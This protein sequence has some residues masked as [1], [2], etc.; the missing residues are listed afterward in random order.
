MA[1]RVTR[2]ATR[3]S[4]G[5]RRAS[6]DAG[7]PRFEIYVIDSGWPSP[8]ADVVRAALPLFMKFLNRHDVYVL[9]ADESVGFLQGHPQL[10]GKD[11]MVA[12]L[13]REAI[14]RES[15]DG[16]GARLMLG[17]VRDAHRVL[18]LLK[19]LLRIV[20]TPELA[21]DLPGSIRRFVHREGVAGALEI[22]LSTAGRGDA[23][24]GH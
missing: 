3:R 5:R 7:H 9:T 24:S 23:E 19:M 20:N 6:G 10:L 18:A 22:A 11:P 8:A 16:I 1:R 15:Q 14:R 21:A 4:P 17:R 12:V 13:D 2:K